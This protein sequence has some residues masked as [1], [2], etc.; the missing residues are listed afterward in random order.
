MLYWNMDTNEI[1]RMLRL[2]DEKA[3][4]YLYDKYAGALNGIILRSLKS[5][6]LAEE[7]LQ[8]TFLKIW[9]EIETYDHG[10]AQLFT[11]MSGIARSRTS[12]LK[13]SEKYIEMSKTISTPQQKHDSSTYFPNVN[14]QRL[15]SDLGENNREI[16]IYLYLNGC[17][18]SET[19]EQ[20]DI[21]LGTVKTR[22]RSAI[23]EL[24]KKLK[25]EKVPL[26]SSFSMIIIL[27]PFLCL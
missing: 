14:A 9:D 23:L 17:S 19:A 4:V 13:C 16:L 21:P 26:T 6:I 20:I 18:P 25:D 27:I 7:V 22:V 2:R 15:M 24:R 8:Q 10:T 5:E 1:I 3:L 11:W 12:E